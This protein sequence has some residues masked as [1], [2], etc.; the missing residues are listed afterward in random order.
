MSVV[1]PVISSEDIIAAA[2]APGGA[3]TYSAV[4]IQKLLFLIDKEIPDLIAG[5]HFNFRPYFYG[6]FDKGVYDAVEKLEQRGEMKVERDPSLRIRN[7]RLTQT[8]IERGNTVLGAIPENAKSYIQRVS[9]FVQRSTFGALVS[10]I[11]KKYPEMKKNSIFP[12]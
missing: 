12:G 2:L 1:H 3:R 9:S 11:Y 10:A 4:Q 7:F 6:P 5:P 8:G